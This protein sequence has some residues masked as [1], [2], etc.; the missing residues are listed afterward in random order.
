M[1]TRGHT[2][3]E[4]VLGMA[5]LTIILVMLFAVYQLGANA[6]KKAEVRTELAQQAQQVAGHL[7]REVERSIYDG[8]SLDSVPNATT[9]VNDT[10]LSL[11]SCWND[12]TSRFEYDAVARGPLWQK[13]TIIYFDSVQG[14]VFATQTPLAPPAATPVPLANPATFRSGGRLLASDVVRCD[15]ALAQDR[16]EMTLELA[17]RRYGSQTPETVALPVRAIFRN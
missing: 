6:W 5:I 11:L 12:A 8:A 3:L 17:R 14:K 4:L 13:Y 1:N 9:G 15:F 7:T 16:L 2:L 10:T